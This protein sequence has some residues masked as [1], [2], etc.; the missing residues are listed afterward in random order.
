MK[1]LVR[2]ITLILF[3][4]IGAYSFA[5]KPPIKLGD[6]SKQDIEMTVYDAD[7]NADAVILCDYGYLTF[8]YNIK[9][10]QWENQLKRICRI[11]IL[12]DDG[13]EW[14]T[15]QISLYDDNNTEQSIS[16]IK[17]FTYNIENGKVQKTKLSKDDIFKEKTSKNYNRVKFTMPNVK[18]GSVVEF[19]YTVFSN[20]I[21]ILDQWQFQRSIPVKWSEY[22]VCIPEYLTYLKNSQGY[23][24]FYKYETTSKSQTL[25]W[26]STERATV[27]LQGSTR[28]LRLKIAFAIVMM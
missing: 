6:V 13:Y 19:S 2:T 25:S 27:S 23:G 4:S 1:A 16:G 9:E 12:N 26:T 11:K 10:G 17:G 22:K 18:E 8:S 14:A 24:S 15:E 5:G 7:P 3:L 20:Y 28:P 21:T